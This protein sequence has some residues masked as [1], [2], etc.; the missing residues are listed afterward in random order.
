MRRFGIWAVSALIAVPVYFLTSASGM[1]GVLV[2]ILTFIG[3]LAG[4]FLGSYM[5]QRRRTPP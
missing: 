4:S 5:M 1:S 2:L 3:A